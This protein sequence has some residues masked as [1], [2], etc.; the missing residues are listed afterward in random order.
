[1]KRVYLLT[2]MALVVC[3]SMLTGC[4]KNGDFTYI[5]AGS[6]GQGDNPSNLEIDGAYVYH[7]TWELDGQVVDQAY[8][9]D[10]DT[11]IRVGRMPL[12]S[13]IYLA[14]DTE[15]R[16]E[17]YNT[18]NPQN[19][20]LKVKEQLWT[21]YS[22]SRYALEGKDFMMYAEYGGRQHEIHIVVDRT[23]PFVL[24]SSDKKSL[25]VTLD[26]NAITVDGSVVRTF[27]PA[28]RLYFR[29]TEEQE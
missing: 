24:R 5:P 29:S 14:L 11:T 28:S 21:D 27:S 9:W 17:A 19:Y 4:S 18:V 23:S 26:M 15:N 13:L 3:G 22:F 10:R 20:E 1:M 12:S 8:V 6:G 7:G 16:A 25:A 2:V